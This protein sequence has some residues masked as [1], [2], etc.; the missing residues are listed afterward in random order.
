ML[1]VEEKKKMFGGGHTIP[2]VDGDPWCPELGICLPENDFD[3]CPSSPG[4]GGIPGSGGGWAPCV[5]GGEPLPPG[6][7]V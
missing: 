2:C 6:S 5:E 3:V 7:C 1:S 4:N